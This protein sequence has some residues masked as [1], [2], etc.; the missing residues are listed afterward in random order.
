MCPR[1]KKDKKEKKLRK[2][3]KFQAGDGFELSTSWWQ[4]ALEGPW[5]YHRTTFTSD[6]GEAKITILLSSIKTLI[7]WLIPPR[8]Q[9]TRV[10]AKLSFT[11]AETDYKV[12]PMAHWLSDS[13]KM[14]VF[15]IP[16]AVSTLG[17][18]S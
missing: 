8:A 3:K 13:F 4:G 18:G 12:S 11:L 10:F 7:F 5:Q 2:I 16:G 17:S 1:K 14:A 15:V 6:Y 9:K